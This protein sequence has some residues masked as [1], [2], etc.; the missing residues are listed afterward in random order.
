[1]MEMTRECVLQNNSAKHI[2]WGFVHFWWSKMKNAWVLTPTTG[3]RFLQPPS[4]A[5]MVSKRVLQNYS[6]KH[7]F[8]RLFW[9]FQGQR[10]K[11]HQIWPRVWVSRVLST[12]LCWKWEVNEFC[13]IILLN[14][15]LEVILGFWR[16]KMKNTSNLT[17]SMSFR[18]SQHSSVVEMSS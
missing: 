17:S 8:W 18:G 9:V 6:A 10:W 14:T 7:V 2:F 12:H 3:F 4:L 11:M 5:T 16:S 15:I 1:M 13:R